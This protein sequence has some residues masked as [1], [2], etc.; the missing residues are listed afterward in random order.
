MQ[1]LS[2]VFLAGGSIIDLDATFFVQ[3]LI[4]VIAFFMLRSLVFKPVMT[5]F[6]AREEAIDGARVD[7]RRME[8]EAADKAGTFDEE[9]HK[10]RMD[11]GHERDRLRADGQRLERQLLEKVRLETQETLSA[12][13]ARM[14]SEAAKV[15]N[16]IRATIP[17][18]AQDIA[19]RL[20]DR[21]VQ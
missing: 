7:A 12:A 4:F 6:D 5:L 8:K 21:E 13:E 3:L 9:M 10:V 15:R 2:T 1:L 20:L 18:L 16:E 14:A 11:A 19:S 17:G